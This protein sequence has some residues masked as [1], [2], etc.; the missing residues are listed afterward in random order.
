MMAKCSVPPQ[1]IR[2]FQFQ[3]LNGLRELVE[4]RRF[5]VW[6]LDQFGVLHDGKQPYPGA[7]S[8]LENIAKTGAKMVIISNSSRRSSVTIEKVKGL[9]FDASLFLGAITSGELT[10]QYLQR[11][12]DP[13][14]AALGRSCI[15]FTWNGRGA[16]SLEGLDLQVVEN[17]EEAEFVLAHG[18]EAL[19][20]AD[21]GA[22]SMKLEDLETILELCAAKG[23]PMVVANPDY[24]TVEARDLRVMP[25]TLAAKYEK[26][27][28]EVKWM[29][30]PDEIIYKSAMAMAGSD[31]SECIAVGDSLHHDIKGANAAGI[32][33]VFITGGIH[34]TELGLHGFGEVANSS[35][36]QSLATKYDAYPSYVLSAFTW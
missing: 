24:V 14:F 32:K 16:I 22:R 13:W 29:G 10:H 17:V 12:D 28:G 30:K 3:S 23:I 34:A 20:N 9:G 21:G 31:V 36:V 7:I 33:S 19:G 26:L 18:T 1:Q 6:L 11:R 27:G 25:G 8:T 35:S 2:P 4:T 15:H 5:K